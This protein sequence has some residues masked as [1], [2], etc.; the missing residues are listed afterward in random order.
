MI[1][2]SL[3]GVFIISILLVFRVNCMVVNIKGKDAR[4]PISIF[5]NI[6]GWPIGAMLGAISVLLLCVYELPGYYIQLADLMLT[7]IVIAVID[8][9]RRIIPDYVTISFLLAQLAAVFC[10]AQENISVWNILVSAVILLVLILVSRLSKEQIG[11]GD[12]KLITAVNLIY[13]LPFTVYSLLLAM[14]A[15]LFFAIPLLIMKKIKLKSQLPFAPFYLTGVLAY[16]I[17]NLI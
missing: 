6:H 2:I 12:V 5:K 15:I 16:I 14:I 10:V 11:M 9:K 17:L 8:I 4:N 3:L 13:G 1:Y 7:L